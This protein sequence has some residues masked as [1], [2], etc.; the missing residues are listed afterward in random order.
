[1]KLQT[2]V[3]LNAAASVALFAGLAIAQPHDHHDLAQAPAEAQT[4]APVSDELADGEV[5]RIDI[6]SGKLTLRHGEIKSLDMPPMSM[7]FYVDD[8]GLLNDLKVGD[9]IRFAVEQQNGKMVITHIEP[10]PF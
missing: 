10:A 8:P 9:M 4:Q 2:F 1:M 6:S 3:S 5:R 7:V